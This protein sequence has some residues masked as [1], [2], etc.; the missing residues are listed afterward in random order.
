MLHEDAVDKDKQDLRQIL[1]AASLDSA[2]TELGSDPANMVAPRSPMIS[3]QPGMDQVEKPPLLPGLM[4]GYGDLKKP[5]V[6]PSYFMLFRN[7]NKIAEHKPERKLQ[8]L[9]LYNPLKETMEVSAEAINPSYPLAA[10]TPV[11]QTR[12]GGPSCIPTSYRWV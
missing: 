11:C 3:V 4:S 12:P 7:F 6:N 1:F 10:D 8:E 5:V 2:A 9:L